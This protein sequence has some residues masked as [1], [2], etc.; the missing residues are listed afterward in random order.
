MEAKG[1]PNSRETPLSSSKPPVRGGQL[2]PRH[3][4][5]KELTG[6]VQCDISAPGQESERESVWLTAQAE[7]KASPAHTPGILTPGIWE[8]TRWRWTL[9]ASSGRSS[10]CAG[11]HWTG[12]LS[13]WG[14]SAT[15]TRGQQL[16]QAGKTLPRD[17][18]CKG[19]LWQR[20][21]SSL[22]GTGDTPGV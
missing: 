15:G 10:G 2:L 9:A 13:G 17:C 21:H 20:G 8:S 16:Q 4:P 11:P 1:H 6:A 5:W 12:R 7:G 14:G 22:Q 19:I 18:V 3:S